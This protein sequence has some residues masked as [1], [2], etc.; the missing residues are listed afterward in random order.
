MPVNYYPLVTVQLPLYNERFVAARLIDASARLQ[1]PKNRIEIQVLDDSDD[2]TVQIIDERVH[3][4]SHKGIT[5]HVLRR[6]DRSGFKAGALGSWTDKGER[7]IHR[8]FRRRFSS[9]P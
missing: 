8:C 1:W 6:K 2:D 7:G 9:Q 4:W 5:I 3:Y